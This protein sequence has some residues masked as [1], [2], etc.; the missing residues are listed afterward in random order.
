MGDEREE[1]LSRSSA[2]GR[3][4]AP[5]LT[6]LHSRRNNEMFELTMK[7]LGNPQMISRKYQYARD[8]YNSAILFNIYNININ[9]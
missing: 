4:T 6:C 8:K 7:C 1:S 9:D 2:K 3:T 5:N